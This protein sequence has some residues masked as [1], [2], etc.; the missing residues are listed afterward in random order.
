MMYREDGSTSFAGLERIVGRLGNRLGS[1]VLQHTG[2]F[3]GGVAKA[4]YAVVPGS[5]PGELRG[6]RGEGDFASGH[7]PQYPMALD[8]DFE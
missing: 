1:F 3:E 2:I 6:L 4:H 5:G 7:A 8:Y